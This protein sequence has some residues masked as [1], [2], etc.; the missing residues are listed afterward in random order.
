[1]NGISIDVEGSL[2]PNLLTMLVQL[3]S[4]FVIFLAVKKWLWK[5]VREIIAK[6][7]DKMQESLDSAEKIN[8]DAQKY[9]DDAKKELSDAKKSSIEIIDSA[10]LEADNLKFGILNDAKRQAQN[11]LDEADK[12]I[13]NAK[14]EMQN[15]LHDEIVNVAMAAVE[16][17][18]N[19]KA[20]SD[21]DKKAIDDFVNEVKK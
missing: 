9:L 1:M 21:D 8:L 10:K 20:T 7:A 5:P 19:Q 15:E 14:K 12:R 18:L 6:R 13:D 4:T 2:F 11:K 17:L 3:L 16:K